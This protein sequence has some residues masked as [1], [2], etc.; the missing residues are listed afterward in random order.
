MKKVYSLIVI[1]VLCLSLPGCIPLWA[2][3]EK[4]YPQFSFSVTDL[5]GNIITES[6]FA[7]HKVTM[8]NFWEP[9]CS[10]CVHEMPDL[11]LLYQAYKDDGFYIIGIYSSTDMLS[12][13]KS[14][15]QS[16]GTTYPIADYCDTFDQFQTGYVPT[17]IFVDQKGQVMK[18]KGGTSLTGARSFTDWGS[19]VSDLL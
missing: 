13:V 18:V 7:E 12:S 17:T 4:T 10:P 2:L 1:L 15:V 3:N 14:I 19:I 11:E 6:V 16:A 8:I 5:S 9:W